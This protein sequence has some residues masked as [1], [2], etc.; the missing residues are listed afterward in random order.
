MVQYIPRLTASLV[1]SLALVA[2][3][4]SNKDDTAAADSALNS[5]IQLANRDTAAQPALTDVPAASATNPAP[6]TAAPRTTHAGAYAGHDHSPADHH[7]H[8]ERQHRNSHAR[9]LGGESRNDSG[10]RD[11]ESRVRLEDLHQH[12]QGR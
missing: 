1:L 11:A 12:Q 3:A 8:V 4:C 2:S 6:S 9:W 7:D 5:D 10:R